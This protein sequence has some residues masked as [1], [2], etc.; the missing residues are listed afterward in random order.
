M[1][2]SK[3]ARA[4]LGC[5]TA[6]TWPTRGEAASGDASPGDPRSY[7]P[8]AY[9]RYRARLSL[10]GQ[11]SG[12]GGL[13]REAGEQGA[14]PP[15]PEPRATAKPARPHEWDAAAAAAAAAELAV[16]C[17]HAPPLPR[18][19]SSASPPAARCEP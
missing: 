16:D 14:G 5:A 1:G 12:P 3:D 13:R 18:D 17:A 2:V 9:L 4:S 10:G 6:A 7:L 15:P 19:A 11:S 8:P